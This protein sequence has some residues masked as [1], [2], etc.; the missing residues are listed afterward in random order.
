MQWI[1][2]C[3]LLDIGQL[4]EAA[5]WSDRA[6]RSPR[7][8]IVM[9]LLAVVANQKAGNL[10]TATIWANQL[11][12]RDPTM[13]RTDLFRMM[14]FQNLELRNQIESSLKGFGF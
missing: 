11:R 8:T 3:A 13:K 1:K 2:A 6:A 10:A 5:E 9:P 12:Q 14:P 4:Q 7:S